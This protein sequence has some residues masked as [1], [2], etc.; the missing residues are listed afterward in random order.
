VNDI[1]T[2]GTIDWFL[3]EAKGKEL[4]GELVPPLLDLVNR[5]LIRTSTR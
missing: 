3:I 4:N 5:R 2:T 1:E